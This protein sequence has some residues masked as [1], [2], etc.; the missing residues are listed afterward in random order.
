MSLSNSRTGLKFA[1]AFARESQADHRR[2]EVQSRLG[3]F[4][5]TAR[6][7]VGGHAEYQHKAVL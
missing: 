2:T 7:A 3:D 6:M 1:V 4:D 5:E